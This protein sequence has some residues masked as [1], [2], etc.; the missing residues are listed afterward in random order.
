MSMGHGWTLLLTKRQHNDAGMKG[1]ILAGFSLDT[2]VRHRP[3][4]VRMAVRK[5]QRS[6]VRIA[7]VH[8]PHAMMGRATL[9]DSVGVLRGLRFPPTLH[10]ESHMQYCLWS[11]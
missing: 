10:C 2:N 7:I 11:Q 9:F 1:D 6:R 5:P 4:Y 3:T 8:D